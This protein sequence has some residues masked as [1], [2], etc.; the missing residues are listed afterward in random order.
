MQTLTTH[1]AALLTPCAHGGPLFRAR[2]KAS[3]EDFCVSEQL[4]LEFT[5]TGEHLYLHIEKTG[6]NTSDLVKG[7]ARCFGVP[8]KDI[9]VAGMKDKHA[10]TSQWVS[11]LS[12]Q[13]VQPL[14]Q[15]LAS[16]DAPPFRLLDSA[17]HSKKLRSGAH[18]GNRFVIRL[19]EVEPLV[20]CEALHETVS[21]RIQQLVHQG[22]PNYY[23]PQ[24]FG[25]AGNNLRSAITWLTAGDSIASMAR[26]KRSLYLSAVRSAAFNRVLAARVQAGTWNRLRAGDLCMLDGTRSVFTATDE[27]FAA[28]QARMD[29]FDV[30]PSSPLIGDGEWMSTGNAKAIDQAVLTADAHHEALVKALTKMRVEASHRATRALCKD[31]NHRWLDEKTLEISMGLAPGVFATTLLAELFVENT[32]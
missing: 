22:F 23:G 24:R 21:N 30:H 28:T 32:E 10:V 14:V 25:K 5:G 9:G 18:T 13:D 1:D 4:N 19:T 31:L 11:V 29:A 12:P 16:D 20:C 17:R 6:R 27:E 15:W 26:D 7:L 3:A 2:F 8:K